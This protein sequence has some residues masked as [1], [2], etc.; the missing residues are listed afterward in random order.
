LYYFRRHFR[1]AIILR[2]LIIADAADYADAYFS[3]AIIFAIT[4]HFFAISPLL[5]R[6]HY[7][8][9]RRCR[10]RACVMLR[11]YA[12]CAAAMPG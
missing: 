5:I 12:D 6:V 7:A 3:F 11:D 10:R 8:I 9:A 2:R 4:L 1:H